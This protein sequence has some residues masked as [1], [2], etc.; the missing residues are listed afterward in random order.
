MRPNNVKARTAAMLS[1]GRTCA[2]P[3]GTALN[4]W[5]RAQEMTVMTARALINPTKDTNRDVFIDSRLAMK[6]VLSP[7]LPIKTS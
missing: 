7:I 6:K 5:P 2:R 3:N 4:T 1:S